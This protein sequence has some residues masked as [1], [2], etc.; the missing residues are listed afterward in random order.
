M[1][2]KNSKVS[3]IVQEP[4][5]VFDDL[6]NRRTMENNAQ[7]NNPIKTNRRVYDWYSNPSNKGAR[8]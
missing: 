8:K 5:I 7:E 3:F 4:C 1:W 2:F 6:Q